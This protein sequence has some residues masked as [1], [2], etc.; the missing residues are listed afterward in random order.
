MYKNFLERLNKACV[1]SD[2]SFC[3]VRAGKS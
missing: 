3:M 2:V 1:I